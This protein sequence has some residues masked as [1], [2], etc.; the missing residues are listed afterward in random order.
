MRLQ[1]AQ[2]LLALRLNLCAGL[3][4]DS[5]VVDSLGTGADR[6]AWSLGAIADSLDEVLCN[7]A[8]PDSVYEDLLE[9]LRRVNGRD[10]LASSTSADEAS[11]SV[12]RA[13]DVRPA[14]GAL[15][16][17]APNRFASR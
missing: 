17:A 1:A 15:N 13:L 7:S 5:L 3:V 12:A 4:C 9:L 10:L 6:H 8:T 11:A 14:G 2:E 16:R